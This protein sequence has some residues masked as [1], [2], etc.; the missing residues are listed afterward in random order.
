MQGCIRKILQ[1]SSLLRVCLADWTLRY[2]TRLQRCGLQEQAQVVGACLMGCV[3][4]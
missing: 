3:G 4:R 1:R 2:S